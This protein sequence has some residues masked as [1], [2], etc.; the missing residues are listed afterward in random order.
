[1][2]LSL[3]VLIVGLVWHFGV[4]FE[5]DTI[6]ATLKDSSTTNPKTTSQSKVQQPPTQDG[7]QKVFLQN[8]DY[9]I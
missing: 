7:G 3:L 2:T 8:V 4:P 5:V 9:L 1:M 6:L